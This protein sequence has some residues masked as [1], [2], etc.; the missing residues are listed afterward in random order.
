MGNY[1]TP[2]D[3]IFVTGAD[4]HPGGGINGASGRACA[5]AVL[6]SIGSHR[7]LRRLGRAGA[8]ARQLGGSIAA[9]RALPQVCVTDIGEDRRF[10]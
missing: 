2:I 9:A 3:G 5:H 10:R 4:T 1:A 8:I 7:S 6:R